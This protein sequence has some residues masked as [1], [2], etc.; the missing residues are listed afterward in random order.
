[1]GSFRRKE[2]TANLAIYHL[3]VLSMTPKTK[4]LN[5]RPA[6]FLPGEHRTK[7]AGYIERVRRIVETAD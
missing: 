7:R 4:L 2:K 6:R 1:M 3:D 5:A